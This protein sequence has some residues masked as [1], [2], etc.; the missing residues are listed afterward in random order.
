M[1][2]LKK[3]P[4]SKI[5][6]KLLFLTLILLLFCIN[7]YA[8]SDFI[9]A[10]VND[11]AITKSDL[12]YRLQYF[13]KNS[14]YKIKTRKEYLS[15]SKFMLDKMIEESLITQHAQS[16]DINVEKDEIDQAINYIAISKKINPAKYKKQLKANKNHYNSFKNQII[17]ELLWSKIVKNFINPLIK[18]HQYE[19]KEMLIRNNLIKKQKKFK[20]NEIILKKSDDADI[21]A[22]KIY[23]ELQKGADFDDM[24]RNFSF[25]YFEDKNIRW[26]DESQLNNEVFKNIKDLLTNQYSKPIKLGN[27]IRII[28]IINI[29]EVDKIKTENI[30]QIKQ[31]IKNEKLAIKTKSYMIKLKKNSYIEIAP[32][33]N[34]NF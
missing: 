25:N 21:I 6:V 16:K 22:Q 20:F 29:K 32:K 27:F 26:L 14:S 30:E 11:L 7:S 5:F 18:V 10:K 15:L 17:S 3:N 31:H 23:L 9:I 24:A 2:F 12:D 1:I 34:I 8:K 13:L 19:I 33:F 4:Q 28:K